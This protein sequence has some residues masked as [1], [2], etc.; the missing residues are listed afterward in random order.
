MTTAVSFWSKTAAAAISC[1]ATTVAIAH[2]AWLVAAVCAAGT[3]AF[4]ANAVL[5]ERRAYLDAVRD[6]QLFLGWL[7]H[8]DGQ[9]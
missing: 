7:N 6:W 9:P 5:G 3:L 4:A 2:Q 8:R 1:G